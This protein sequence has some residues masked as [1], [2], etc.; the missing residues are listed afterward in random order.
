MSFGHFHLGTI[1]ALAGKLAFITN[2]KNQVCFKLIT[3]G[4]GS[5]K[6]CFFFSSL[7]SFQFLILISTPQ[8]SK[9]IPP[10]FWVGGLAKKAKT[11]RPRRRKR[12]QVGSLVV[13]FPTKFLEILLPYTQVGHHPLWPPLLSL[14]CPCLLF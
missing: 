12:N 4:C 3:E 5:P 2:D 7:F 10:P 11:E 9:L 1:C 14:C 13:V 6:K 8:V